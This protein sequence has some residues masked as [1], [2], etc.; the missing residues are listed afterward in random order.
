MMKL[1]NKKGCEKLH[2][3]ELLLVGDLL[4]T[5]AI[6]RTRDRIEEELESQIRMRCPLKA[7]LPVKS[8]GAQYT[9]KQSKSDVPRNDQ[10]PQWI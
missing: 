4:C 9:E 2:L 7:F 1:T 6:L 5:N 3:R 8:F 10:V